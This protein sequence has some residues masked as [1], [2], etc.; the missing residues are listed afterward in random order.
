MIILKPEFRTLPNTTQDR[1]EEGKISDVSFLQ[2]KASH[3]LFLMPLVLTGRGSH[4]YLLFLTEYALPK[5]SLLWGSLKWSISYLQMLEAQMSRHGDLE[6]SRKIRK[7]L[8]C[9]AFILWPYWQSVCGSVYH[10]ELDS[11]EVILN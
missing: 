9:R 2:T 8:I 7:G 3:S 10:D 11:Q 5:F 1:K 4:T 6:G